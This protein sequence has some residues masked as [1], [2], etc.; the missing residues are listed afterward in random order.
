[1]KINIRA[2]REAKIYISL[3]LAMDG[4]QF[5]AD[6]FRRTLLD[7]LLSL[8]VAT[9]ENCAFRIIFRRIFAGIYISR[10]RYIYANTVR[11]ARLR[12]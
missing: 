8:N 2:I 10:L 3:I 11:Y 1:M 7:T 4:I 12:H 9:V 6:C 5:I